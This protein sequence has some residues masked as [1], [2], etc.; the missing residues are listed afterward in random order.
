M[1]VL[2]RLGR[3]TISLRAE[4]ACGEGLGREGGLSGSGVGVWVDDP[5][6][7]RCTHPKEHHVKHPHV[8][9]KLRSPPARSTEGT[10]RVLASAATSRVAT[11]TKSHPLDLVHGQ[12]GELEGYEH[13]QHKSCRQH[14][15]RVEGIFSG[16]CCCSRNYFLS[17]HIRC[18]CDA[19]LKC[20]FLQGI[21]I[22]LMR[23]FDRLL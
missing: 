13:G 21:P 20:L 15:G 10:T 11:E 17:S 2:S 9:K 8:A 14:S 6:N 3:V 7:F 23:I 16:N 18:C 1:E 5:E 4:L 12:T 22:V 19:V